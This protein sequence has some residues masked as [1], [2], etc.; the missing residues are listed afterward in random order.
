MYRELLSRPQKKKIKFDFGIEKMQYKDLDQVVQIE[1]SSFSDPWSKENFKDDLESSI[2]VLL[3]AKVNKKIIG[4]ICGWIVGKEAEI[5]NVAV[6]PVYRRKNVARTLLRKILNEFR[7]KNCHSITLEVRN[8]NS[9]A[10]KLYSSF[11]FTEIYRRKSY[12][13]EPTEDALVMFKIL[14]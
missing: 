2:S 1:N 8:S 9:A 11:G 5:S 6:A 3:V 10:F 13:R 14:N 7:N 12:Y 4:Y